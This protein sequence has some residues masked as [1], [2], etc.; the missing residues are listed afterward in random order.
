VLPKSAL[1]KACDYL[2]KCWE[3][4]TRDSEHGETRIDDNPEENAIRPSAIGRRIWL[5]VGHPDAGQRSAI[6]HSLL[7]SCQRRGID[8]LA[9]LRDVL[10]RQPRMTT[11]DNPS[12]LPHVNWKH[13]A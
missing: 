12:A 7:V 4:L 3:P 2:L 10:N 13:A 5:I 9:L 1:V 6:S 8:P 11:K